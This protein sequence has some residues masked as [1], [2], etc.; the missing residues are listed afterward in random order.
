[1]AED[2]EALGCVRIPSQPFELVQAMAPA[3]PEP[4]MVHESTYGWYLAAAVLKDLGAWV[5]LAHALGN[6]WGNRRVKNDERDAK[7][8]AAVLRLGRLAEG[9]TVGRRS[10]SSAPTTTSKPAPRLLSSSME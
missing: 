1:M 8:L 7:D 4:E 10:S 5:H 2:S 3:E 6:N 9:P